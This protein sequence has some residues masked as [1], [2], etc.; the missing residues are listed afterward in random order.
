MISAVVG[1]ER[2]VKSVGRDLD[3]QE[4]KGQTFFMLLEDR[5]V[6]RYRQLPRRESV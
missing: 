5:G 6:K 2:H 3:R 1:T 4:G